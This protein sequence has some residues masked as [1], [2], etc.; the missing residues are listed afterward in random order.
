MLRLSSVQETI[1]VGAAVGMMLAAGCNT[2]PS[3]EQVQQDAAQTTAAVKQGAQEAAA[4]T[5]QAASV[6]VSDVNDVAAGV[7]QGLKENDSSKADLN[8]S[9]QVRLALLPGI[10]MAKAGEIVDKR[11]YRSTHQLVSRG[12]VTADEYGKIASLVTVK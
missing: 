6:A 11:P 4:A 10:S 3:H 7:R 8:T 9:S 1:A 2:A 5:K 12:I